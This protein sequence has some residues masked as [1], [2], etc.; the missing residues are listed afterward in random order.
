MQR[1]FAHL[2]MNKS[3]RCKNDRAAKLVGFPLEVADLPT[4]LFNQQHARS[5]VPL[6]EAEFPET[7]EA[8]GG[9]AGE[10]ERGRAVAAHAVRLLRELAVILQIRAESAVAHGEAGAKQAG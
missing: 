6:I 1:Y 7:I 2:L 4:G 10:I 8:A 3:V 5:H 9:H